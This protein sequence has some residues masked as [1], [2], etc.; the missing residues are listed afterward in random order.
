MRRALLLG[1][2][3]A[4]G[5]N[6]VPFD[7]EIVFANEV[8]SVTTVSSRDDD[9]EI[10]V[11][12]L[13]ITARKSYQ[14]YDDAQGDELLFL[15]MVDSA[16]ASPTATVGACRDE[17]TDQCGP[18]DEITVERLYV[19]PPF[20]SLMWNHLECEGLDGHQEDFRR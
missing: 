1:A 13:T 12:T 5:D 20:M 11:D 7:F 9:V 10:H 16:R 14:S 3:A 2:L 8:N 17:C 19:S 4:C 18:L 6:K 15:V